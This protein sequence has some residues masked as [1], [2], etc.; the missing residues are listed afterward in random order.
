MGP[1]GA[2]FYPSPETQGA[3]PSLGAAF[4]QQYKLSAVEFWS[5][6]TQLTVCVGWGAFRGILWGSGVP[7]NLDT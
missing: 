7:G 4:D 6:G 5:L 3:V 2:G 1:A